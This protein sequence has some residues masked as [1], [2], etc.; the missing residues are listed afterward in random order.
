MAANI[1]RMAM[2]DSE[3]AARRLGVKVPTLYA[4]VSRGLISTMKGPDGRRNLFSTEEI[5]ERARRLKRARN[6]EIRVATIATG[7][8]KLHEDGPSYRGVSAVS[9]VAS[10]S[11]EQV[12]DLLWQAAPGPWE[13][14]PEAVD[15]ANRES[16]AARDRIRLAVVV[17]GAADP[18]RADLRP[19]AV[20]HAARRLI[21]TAVLALDPGLSPDGEQV[22]R[23][24][25]QRLPG[26]VDQGSIAERGEG[27]GL[28]HARADL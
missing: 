27:S 9:L 28:G 8:S 13:A 12:A 24:A 16:F 18:L 10:S 22:H 20:H 26:P 15:V 21:A 23:P 2:L 1:S 5:E 11:Y 6:N 25:G 7:V 3:E 4:Y 17:A 14:A 19:A